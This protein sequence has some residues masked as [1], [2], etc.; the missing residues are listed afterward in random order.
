MTKQTDGTAKVYLWMS[1]L[2]SPYL[3]N[4]LPAPAKKAAPAATPVSVG[5]DE[6]CQGLKKAFEGRVNSF[7]DL[8]AAKGNGGTSDATIKLSG[9]AQCAVNATTKSHSNEAGRQYVCYWMETSPSG[10]DT[11]FRDLISRFQI[12][13]PSDWSIRQEDQAEELT[14]AKVKAWCAV[15]PTGK[16]EMCMYIA[17]ESVGLHIK[18]WN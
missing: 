16:Q 10:A 18:A 9:A 13:A 7:D 5:C 11:R 8:R 3:V 6:L 4:R 1:S 17:G 14:G 12:L 2:S 15:E